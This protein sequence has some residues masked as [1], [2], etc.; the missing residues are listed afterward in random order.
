[1]RGPRV[2][3]AG[4][5]AALA[6]GEP[7]PAA[8]PEPEPPDPPPSPAPPRPAVHLEPV[9]ARDADLLERWPSLAHYPRVPPALASGLRARDP[10]AIFRGLELAFEPDRWAEVD[11]WER[12]GHIR[13]AEP[14]GFCRTDAGRPVRLSSGTYDLGCLGGFL[15]GVRLLWLPRLELADLVPCEPPGGFESCRD[16]AQAGRAAL[17]QI[18]A[19][20]PE[21]VLPRGLE[22][23]DLRLAELGPEALIAALVPDVLHLCS[24]SHR[25]RARGGERMY[26]H[27]MIVDPPAIAS[28]VC[29]CSTPPGPPASPG[30]RCDPSAST[31][32]RAA[33]WPSTTP[34]A[35]TPT[36]PSSAAC[37]CAR[38]RP[39]SQVH[40]DRSHAPG[41]NVHPPPPRPAVRLGPGPPPGPLRR[42]LH[43]RGSPRRRRRRARQPRQPR[44]R[45]R[46]SPAAAPR[47]RR[48]LY[49]AGLVPRLIVSGGQDPGSPYEADV[50]RDYL[51]ARGVPAERIA[52]DRGGVNTHATARFVAADLRARGERSAIA[53]SQYYH[54]TRTKLA[55]RRFGVDATGAH[56]DL[57]LELR[58]PWSLLRE[59]VGFYAYLFK[60]Y[61]L[62]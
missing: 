57:E 47:S 45:A 11:A 3:T 29:T 6:C 22:V 8:F 25:A 50:M 28:A 23:L 42:R 43:R 17:L 20:L 49:A 30:E 7:A 38:R 2:L 5:A 15:E 39:K 32:T 21:G 44:R 27:M 46:A 54:L 48:A 31:A 9:D 56:A 4:L 34:S 53:V 52:V 33:S 35:T 55:L 36:P 26:H 1:M 18:A 16:G 59:V 12:L 61:R 19:R 14:A 40:E 60:D 62:D 37:P 24:V 10:A 41:A 51:V 58:E 13:L